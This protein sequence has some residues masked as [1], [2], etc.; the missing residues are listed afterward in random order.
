MQ[1]DDRQLPF[2]SFV[3]PVRNARRLLAGCLRS[4]ERNEYPRS[5]V[6]IIVADNGSTDGSRG[7]A[8]DF[9]AVVLNLPGLTPAE[10]RN[11]GAAA[12]SGDVLAFVD[13]D[14]EIAADWI[15]W[16]AVA[17]RDPRV[18]AAGADYHGPAATW[19]Q[20]SYD[21]LRGH[22]IGRRDVEWIGSGNIAVARSAFER[23]GGFEARLITCEDVD[24]CRRLRAAGYRIVADHR[25]HSTHFGDPRTLVELF[26]GELWRGR[27]NARVTLR[28]PLSLRSLASL[29]VP[30]L[31][32]L[33]IAASAAAMLARVPG[34]AAAA[35]GT[36]ALVLAFA[37]LRI[38]T[39]IRPASLS[40]PALL[41]VLV[42]AIVHDL[43]RGCA[44]VVR[45]GHTIRHDLSAE[46][47]T[48]AVAPSAAHEA[49]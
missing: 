10:L 26:K 34:A 19:V 20:R 21:A 38:A 37:A 6:E 35:A 29:V 44:L 48:E 4:I 12:A 3:V 9:G 33:L 5:R 30:A 8:R 40:L 16:A 39:R 32:L 42:V 27:D 25:L 1:A 22:A 14:H 23:V 2:I 31:D 36:G 7:V 43:A 24:F 47:S 13:A 15:A 41:Q 46:A 45:T 17:L 11:R 49:R 18:G 28:R